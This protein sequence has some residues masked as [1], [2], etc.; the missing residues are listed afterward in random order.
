MKFNEKTKRM[1]LAGYFETSSPEDIIENTG[2]EIDV[3]LAEKIEPPSPEVIRMIR[4]DIDPA[5]VFIKVPI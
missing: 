3:S 2:F 4:E 1:Y 5:Q